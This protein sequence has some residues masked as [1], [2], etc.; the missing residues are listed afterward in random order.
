MTSMREL[1]ESHRKEQQVKHQQQKMVTLSFM[2]ISLILPSHSIAS[3]L[4]ICVTEAFFCSEQWLGG[5]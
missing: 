5:S 3:D 4:L 1:I 2:Y